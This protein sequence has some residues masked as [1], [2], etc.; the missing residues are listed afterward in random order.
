MSFNTHQYLHQLSFFDGEYEDEEQYSKLWAHIFKMI[1]HKL[2]GLKTI[3][4]NMIR[5][6]LIR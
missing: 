6:K 4:K 2:V 5:W 1:K 3:I